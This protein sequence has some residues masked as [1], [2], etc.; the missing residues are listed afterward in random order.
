MPKTKDV[1]MEQEE[2]TVGETP[3]ETVE[4]MV[5]E[6]LNYI[7]HDKVNFNHQQSL[8]SIDLGRKESVNGVK[9]RQLHVKHQ[10]SSY[11]IMIIEAFS[12]N[13]GGSDQKKT[14]ASFDINM[15]DYDSF[16]KIQQRFF[17]VTKA[18]TIPRMQTFIRELKNISQ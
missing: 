2:S 4:R 12:S 3:S 7:S 5:D 16:V 18:D 11:R 10:N 17:P 9:H 1:E 8:A 15:S 14:L 6:L 13:S